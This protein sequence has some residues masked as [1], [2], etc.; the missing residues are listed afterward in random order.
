MSVDV[1]G[2]KPGSRRLSSDL[3]IAFPL[4]VRGKAMSKPINPLWSIERALRH[5]YVMEPHRASGDF[6]GPL[7]MSRPSHDC[8]LVTAHIRRAMSDPAMKD[9]NWGR[10]ACVKQCDE[11]ASICHMNDY[12]RAKPHCPPNYPM[13][14]IPTHHFISDVATI[15]IWPGVI[16]YRISDVP[17]TGFGKVITIE[18]G[19][20]CEARYDDFN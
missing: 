13:P 12:I 5:G 10:D 7:R 18:H 16:Q 15:A 6:S 14:A 2:H 20:R 1:T 17:Y 11:C 19:I 4:P 3:Q 8:A 9:Q